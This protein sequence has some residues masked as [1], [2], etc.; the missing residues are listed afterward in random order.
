MRSAGMPASIGWDALEGEME[1]A[2]QHAHASRHL[3]GSGSW[4]QGDVP[5]L[6]RAIILYEHSMLCLLRASSNS[7]GT[8]SAGLP[9]ADFVAVR[10]RIAAR[11][12]PS[13]QK[14]GQMIHVAGGGTRDGP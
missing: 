4:R 9:P 5:P 11:H 2:D 12:L 6:R 13:W 3:A 1:R 7:Q 14:A 10:C 8:R